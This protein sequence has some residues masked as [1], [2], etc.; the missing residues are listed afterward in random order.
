MHLSAHYPLL[1]FKIIL[2][3][4]TCSYTLNVHNISF[5]FKIYI[6]HK[7]GAGDKLKQMT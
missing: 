6:P 1:C 5:H 3:F 4:L 2:A 7:G